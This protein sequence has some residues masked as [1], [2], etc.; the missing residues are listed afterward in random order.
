M[1]PSLAAARTYQS[2]IFNTNQSPYDP[3]LSD[4]CA[5]GPAVALMRM[6]AGV[7][8]LSDVLGGYAIGAA[9]GYFIPAVHQVENENLTLYPVYFDTGM[10]ITC[11]VLF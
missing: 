6:E 2:V 8:F 11:S 10:G 9:C 3:M 5:D 4:A 1:H 7:H